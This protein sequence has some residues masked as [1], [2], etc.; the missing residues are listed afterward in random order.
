MQSWMWYVAF[1][2]LLALVACAPAGPPEKPA[3]ANPPA[4]APQATTAPPPPVT[5]RI[6]WRSA[7]IS[8]GAILLALERGYFKEQGIDLE[9]TSIAFT[10]AMM[11]PLAQNQIE[12][13]TGGINAAL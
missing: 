3:T 7:A 9:F 2:L 10:P 11:A 4:A 1:V 5:V 6:G 8:D 12:V 13:A